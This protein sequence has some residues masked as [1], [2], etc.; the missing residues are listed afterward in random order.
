MEKVG[1]IIGNGKLP[2]YFIQEAKEKKLE[3]YPIGLFESVD[4]EIK[5]H[6]RYAQFNIGEVGS[7]VKYLLI[8]DIKK[9]VLLGKVEKELLFKEMKLDKFGEE[10]LKKLPDRKDETLLFGVILFFKLNGI[11][12]LPQNYLL[13]NMMFEK[14]N[15]TSIY[16]SKE[17][18]KT[19]KI[20]REAAKALSKVDAGQSVLCKDESVIALEG[21]EGTDKMIQR[22]G[23]LAGKGTV[24][25]KMARP[26]QDMRVDI[27]AI[28]IDTLKNLVEIG[29]KGIVGEAGKMLFLNRD[30]CISL[31]EKNN[32]FIVG[33]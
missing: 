12:V 8:R 10:L 11:K 20:G 6:D 25:V 9:I 33:E 7:I 4:E 22:G 15:Y 16:P 29:A 1:I 13:K 5:R 30:E 26:Q 17:D 21:I 14:K 23:S 24:L 31:A 32:M 28:G 3:I 18:L 2:L 19:I 27:P